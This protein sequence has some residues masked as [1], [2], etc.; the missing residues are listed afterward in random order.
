MHNL[1]LVIVTPSLRVGGGVR[2]LLALARV[3]SSQGCSCELITT[4]RPDNRQAPEF[5]ERQTFIKPRR[6]NLFFIL[7]AFFQIGYV[8]RDA[9][10]NS[11]IIVSDPLQYL[12]LK[13]ITRRKLFR[14]VQADDL[15]L[16][17]AHARSNFF[18]N[19]LYKFTLI[20]TSHLTNDHTFFNSSYSQQCFIGRVQGGQILFPEVFVPCAS[21]PRERLS[22]PMVIG[23][24]ARI[25]PRKGFSDFVE[26]AS[27][28]DGRHD[29]K[30]LALTQDC[31]PSIET[32]E[33]R[34]TNS[35]LEYQRTLMSID[36][37]L[38]TSDFEGFGLPVLEAMSLGIVPIIKSRP[39][40]D[41]DPSSELTYYSGDDLGQLYDVL[42]DFAAH[43]RGYAAASKISL[44]L[45]SK[46][47]FEG[48]AKRLLSE[49]GLIH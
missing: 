22:N 2:N 24:V 18:F 15:N 43:R 23:T 12:C 49:I 7:L 33:F 26:I 42:D 36:V 32:I 39:N 28:F 14:Y 34:V 38:D 44:K 48:D 21:L 10:S 29:V 17:Q 19:I 35:D 41:V 5:F 40:S 4:E 16:F 1:P 3:A 11:F 6:D 25:H 27:R 45:R 46:F 9:P 13:L 37:F 20:I 47:N 30:F 8:L 31:F